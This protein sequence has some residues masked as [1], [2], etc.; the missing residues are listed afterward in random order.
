MIAIKEYA[1]AIANAMGAEVKE[2][3]KNNGV[4]HYGIMKREG[5]ELATPNVYVDDL[6]ANNVSIN[7]AVSIV[8]ERMESARAESRRLD[9]SVID[10]YETAKPK[11][12]AKLLNGNKNTFEV[13]K[14]AAEYGFDDLVIVPIVVIAINENGMSSTKV[15]KN[16]LEKWGVSADEVIATAMEQT[17]CKVMDMEMF[18]GETLT[19]VTT[20]DMVNGAIAG[21]LKQKEL[22]ERYPQGYWLVPSSIHEMIVFPYKENINGDDLVG[23]IGEVNDEV[24]AREDY[25]GSKPYFISGKEM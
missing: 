13:Y 9:T 22:N 6:L 7:E 8:K 25:L 12:R 4:V 20:L 2:T 3:V 16:M 21:V 24:L 19:I 5:D 1:E 10:T 18:F 23:I 15:S 17:E 11:L 14:S